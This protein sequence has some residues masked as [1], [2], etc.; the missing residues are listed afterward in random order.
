MSV[1]TGTAPKRME[2]ITSRTAARQFDSF[3]QSI[4]RC[5]SL[6]DARRLKNDVVGEI[7]RTR[8]L[9]ANHENEELINGEKAS[10]VVAYLDRLYNAKRHVESRIA[11]LGGADD[12]DGVSRQ[13]LLGLDVIAHQIILETIR[14]P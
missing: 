11:L 8:I 13:S 10:D 5:D 4:N 2:N 9:L 14:Y 1:Q 12:D 6:L 3:I 7:R